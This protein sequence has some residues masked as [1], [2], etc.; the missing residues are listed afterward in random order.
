MCLIWERSIVPGPCS[1]VKSEFP[2]RLSGPCWG[3]GEETGQVED[4]LTGEGLEN[5]ADEVI[6]EG[7]EN[8]AEDVT[9]EGLEKYLS[10]LRLE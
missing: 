3:S 7:L 8:E 5:K 1:L 4:C 2:S 9:G 6:G 10:S